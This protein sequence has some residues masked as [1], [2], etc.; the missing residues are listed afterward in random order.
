MSI[1][2]MLMANLT[3]APSSLLSGYPEQ[4]A[5]ILSCVIGPVLTLLVSSYA[6]RVGRFCGIAQNDKIIFYSLALCVLGNES[7][8]GRDISAVVSTLFDDVDVS[9]QDLRDLVVGEQHVQ[10]DRKCYRDQADNSDESSEQ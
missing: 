3:S 5:I 4:T 2:L 6:E 10:R 9:A 1:P 8:A 7:C